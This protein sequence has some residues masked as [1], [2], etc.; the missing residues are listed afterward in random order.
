MSYRSALLALI[1]ELRRTD[2]PGCDSQVF[3]SAADLFEPEEIH[4]ESQRQIEQE[5]PDLEE[6]DDDF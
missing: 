3:E 6:D 1:A 2:N 5:W 4:E